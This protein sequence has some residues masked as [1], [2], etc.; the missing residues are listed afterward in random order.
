LAAETSTYTRSN[1][2]EAPQISHD[3]YL[4]NMTAQ[5]AE[6][7]DGVI[8]YSAWDTC[9]GRA[10]QD[11]TY[12]SVAPIG[13]ITKTLTAQLVA[14]AVSGGAFGL[15]DPVGALLGLEALHL[16]CIKVRHLLNH[17]HGLDGS[18]AGNAPRESNGRISIDSLV[19]QCG[20][21]KPLFRPGLLYSYG[22][23][24][25]G[26]AAC[27]L[28]RLFGATFETIL[29]KRL[30]EPMG[31][32]LGGCSGVQAVCPSTG[33]N[34]MCLSMQ[35]LMSLLKAQF[36]ELPEDYSGKPATS[37]TTDAVT[38]ISGWSIPRG[39]ALGWKY[40]GGGWFGHSGKWSGV[41]TALRFHARRRIGL[42]V[43]SRR[44]P[45]STIMARVWGHQLPEY[46]R[47]GQ[48]N[49]RDVQFAVEAAIYENAVLRIRV[50]EKGQ[51]GPYISYGLRSHFGEEY[52]AAGSGNSRLILSR[53]GVY[54]LQ[55]QIQKWA[56]WLQFIRPRNGSSVFL[57]N[58]REVFAKRSTS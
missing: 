22:N 56:Q 2:I 54:V 35:D 18:L 24:G 7:R 25:M 52:G 34:A 31:I 19:W 11:D 1:S 44:T 55:P 27:I 12:L 57:W 37:I 32:R 49:T 36:V 43:R 50:S 30:L 4:K 6:C 3:G 20:R 28:E 16:N 14:N 33:G 46:W 58:G 40:F 38:P 45:V 42:V 53:S 15:D 13:C 5:M 23:V 48:D 10:V 51:N 47:S 17:T 8:E 39:I 41:H 29:R 26:L 21:A 9:A